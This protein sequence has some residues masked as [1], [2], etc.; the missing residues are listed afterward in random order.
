MI[1]PYIIILLKSEGLLGMHLDLWNRGKAGPVQ[2]RIFVDDVH[3][4]TSFK[5][6]GPYYNSFSLSPTSNGARRVRY[7]KSPVCHKMRLVYRAWWTIASCF[8]QGLTPQQMNKCSGRKHQ[9]YDVTLRVRRVGRFRIVADHFDI[10]IH[11]CVYA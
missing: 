10:T 2:K 6:W 4:G 1:T 11:G 3:D 7:S 8:K 5:G 9:S